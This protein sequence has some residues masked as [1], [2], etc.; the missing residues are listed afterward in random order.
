MIR[1][2]SSARKSVQ[3]LLNLFHFLVFD[4]LLNELVD[5]I[6][7]LTAAGVFGNCCLDVRAGLGGRDL[8]LCPNRRL[9]QSVEEVRIFPRVSSTLCARCQ[10]VFFVQ[11]F[12]ILIVVLLVRAN[13]IFS[14]LSF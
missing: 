13:R 2:T 5:F 6:S 14:C 7:I 1:G 8:N 4:V 3:T 11:Y 10:V 12:L 9:H